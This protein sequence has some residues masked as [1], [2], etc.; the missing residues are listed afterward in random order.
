MIRTGSKRNAQAR[1]AAQ[2]EPMVWL[3]GGMF[4]IACLMIL[5]LLAFVLWQ[6]LWTLWPRS[7]SIYSRND[8]SILGGELYSKQSI[9]GQDKLYLRT[10]NY[11][12]SSRH[13]AYVSSLELSDETPWTDPD[14][15]LVERKEWG[16]LYG[17][18]K[19]LSWTKSAPEEFAKH[20]ALGLQETSKIDRQLAVAKDQLKRTDHQIAQARLGVRRVELAEKVDLQNAVETGSVEGLSELAKR[21][22]ERLAERNR[23]ADEAMIQINE[24]IAELEA[25]RSERSIVFELPIGQE[26]GKLDADWSEL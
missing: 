3:S 7:Y 21:A 25:K 24:Q 13:F 18:P 26:L 20:V 9:D 8:G 2:G 17:F 4:A 14:L 23:R 5:S 10:G 16:N 15:W 1:I 12:I 22:I 19:D 6:G 11:D